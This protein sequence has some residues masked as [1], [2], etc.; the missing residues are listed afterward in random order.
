MG[1]WA[2]SFRFIDLSGPICRIV[3]NSN[4]A[5]LSGYKESI[6]SPIKMSP[7]GPYH[8]YFSPSLPLLCCRTLKT[9]SSRPRRGS[10]DAILRPGQ[11][12]GKEPLS[13]TWAFTGLSMTTDDWQAQ[14]PYLNNSLLLHIYKLMRIHHLLSKCLEHSLWMHL[15]PLLTLWPSKDLEECNQS[16]V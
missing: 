13:T 11:Q 5:P 1:S 3:M 12:D 9:V 6:R 14:T 10:P 4:P 7:H 2:S 16:V 15:T 8:P